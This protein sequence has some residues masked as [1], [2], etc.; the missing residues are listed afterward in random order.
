VITYAKWEFKRSL[1]LENTF[2]IYEQKVVV[3]LD[4]CLRVATID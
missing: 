4:G 1:Y 3:E 2:F